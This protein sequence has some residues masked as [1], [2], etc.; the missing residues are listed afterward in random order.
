MKYK[1]VELIILS[2]I[3]SLECYAHAG[4]YDRFLDMVACVKSVLNTIFVSQIV[5]YLIIRFTKR[6]RMRLLLQA[7]M[8][9]KNWW[10]NNLAA[11]GLSSFVLTSY[12]VC[13][14]MEAFIGGIIIFFLFWCFY[15]FVV[16]K[17]KVRR[18]LLSGMKAIYFYLIASIGQIIGF[19]VYYFAY[20]LKWYGPYYEYTGSLWDLLGYKL[21]RCDDGGYILLKGMLE[22]AICM[23]IPYFVL[24]VNKAVRFAIY[25]R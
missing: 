21:Y 20:T 12:L 16:L 22:L 17:K 9:C 25:K 4:M 13:F 8:L 6:I 23:A 15:L 14:C 5:V 19:G 3:I 2:L 24:V 7:K 1:D 18:R 11:W 10:I